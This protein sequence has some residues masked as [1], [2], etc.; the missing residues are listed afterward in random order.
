M[1]PG[2]KERE[3]G[4]E[5]RSC[6]PHSQIAQGSFVCPLQLATF[7]SH[8]S[9]PRTSLTL[10]IRVGGCRCESLRYSWGSS[11]TEAR[12]PDNLK[13]KGMGIVKQW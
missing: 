2:I 9:P 4:S 3:M 12:P 8:G 5:A 6:S 7:P 13:L 1:L 11:G 10:R